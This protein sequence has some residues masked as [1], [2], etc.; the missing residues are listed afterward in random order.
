MPVRLRGRDGTIGPLSVRREDLVD[1]ESVM[2]PGD[3]ALA[4][5]GYLRQRGRGS[6]LRWRRD[7]GA[8]HAA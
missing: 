2:Q 4:G 8:A 3:R 7:R 6:T 1:C 5:L